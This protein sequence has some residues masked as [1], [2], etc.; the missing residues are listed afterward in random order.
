[1]IKTRYPGIFKWLSLCSVVLLSGCKAA[2][3]DPKGQVG[4]DERSLIITATLLMLI[5]VIPV[6]VLTLVFAWKYRA[7]N[8]DAKFAP[9]WSHSTAIEIVVWL[10]PCLIIL[11]LGTI[12]WKTTHSLD[13]FKPLETKNDV[14]P[15][16][17]EVVQLDWKWLFIYP[18]Q[19]VASVNQVAFPAHTP[20][21]F[22]ITSDTVMGAFF[23]PQL[24]TQ[25]YSMAGMQT[26]VNL[27]ADHLGTYDG[28]CSNFTGDGFSGM[29]FK[30]IA[31]TPEQFNDW[32]AKAKQSPQKLDNAS[33][34]LL[35]KPSENTP[36]SY[37]STVTPDLFKQIVS[38]YMNMNS[39][40]MNSDS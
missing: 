36:V 40:H 2:L 18:E 5:V 16:T 27:I 10:I 9:D 8:K 1:M 28:I 29:T 11:V 20:V 17:I 12:T 7:S 31:T 14:K 34:E 21:R 33:Y 24:G 19:H 30:A 37:Y 6:I 39:T 23:I 3:L 38:K 26:E 22:K 15:V 32:I 35:A 25:I 13:P 4:M